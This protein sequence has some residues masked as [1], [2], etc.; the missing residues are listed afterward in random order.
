MLRMPARLLVLLLST[1]LSLVLPQVAQSALVEADWRS[2]GDRLLTV[3]T[4]TEL[5]WLD[6]TVTQ[7]LS[8]N[9]VTSQ[10]APPGPF[11]EFRR[12]TNAEVL[13]FWSDAGIPDL[14]GAMPIAGNYAPAKALQQ[15]WG[16]TGEMASGRPGEIYTIA[17]TAE[18]FNPVSGNVEGVAFL[19]VLENQ[20]TAR[21]YVRALLGRGPDE[22]FPFVTHALVRGGSTVA[23]IPEP[24]TIVLLFAG[25]AALCARRGP[26]RLKWSVPKG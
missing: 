11:A 18:S 16:H 13:T 6:V 15:L 25:I 17:T 20:G 1:I 23:P 10:L 24:P 8:W 4:A 2:A 26:E 7:N 3:D 12:A 22:T 9:T 21:A 5:E 19:V 14:S